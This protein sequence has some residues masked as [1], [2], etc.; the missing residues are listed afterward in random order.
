MF[1]VSMYMYIYLDKIPL[2]F[3]FLFVRYND[4]DRD[5]FDKFSALLFD[6]WILL[7][8]SNRRP[9]SPCEFRDDLIS[10]VFFFQNRFGYEKQERKEEEENQAKVSPFNL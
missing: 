2:L 7:M 10:S 4:F 1:T 9:F 6:R 8:G 3:S 5:K